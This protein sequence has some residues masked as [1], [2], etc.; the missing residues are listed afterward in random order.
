MYVCG[1]V[2]WRTSPCLPPPPDGSVT[3]RL[4]PVSESFCGLE[5]ELW[6]RAHRFS[7]A[8]ERRCVV[9]VWECGM[10]RSL[11]MLPDVWKFRTDVVP[12]NAPFPM[13]KII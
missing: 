13:T 12:Q 3:Q 7:P 10:W 8:L 9:P 2:G 11:W 1:V 5:V 6:L 4:W